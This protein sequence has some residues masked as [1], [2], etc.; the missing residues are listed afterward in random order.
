MLYIFYGTDNIMTREKS[1][2]LISGLQKKAPDAELIRITDDS[3]DDV[4]ID[5]LLGTQ[6]LFKQNY[7]I[8]LDN[9]DGVVLGFSDIQL[10][11]MK[12][13]GHVCIVLMGKLKAGDKRHIEKYADKITEY[14]LSS[15]GT[16]GTFD[17][18]SI[19][20]ALKSRNKQ[21]LW[22]VIIEARI[23]GI[24]GESIVGILFWAAKDMV[25]KGQ[26]SRYSEQEL[27]DMVTKIAELPHGARRAGVSV[28]SSLEEFTLKYL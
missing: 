7:I 22:T 16:R 9:I 20:N 10:E 28:H 13:S 11:A 5:E 14:A 21:Q 27:E 18:F 26:T 25:I 23:A 24:E 2:E 1:R 19:A 4:N 8:F 3:E 6:G 17:I 12:L 15:K